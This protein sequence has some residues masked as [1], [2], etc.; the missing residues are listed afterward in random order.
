MREKNRRRVF[1]ERNVKR[2]LGEPSAT[3][4]K[5]GAQLDISERL[6]IPLDCF[7]FVRRRNGHGHVLLLA[8][9]ACMF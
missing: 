8:Y 9:G 1:T 7:W 4:R 5:I 6:A 2:C 3:A